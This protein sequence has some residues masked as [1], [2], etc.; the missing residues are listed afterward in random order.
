M[1]EEAKIQLKK[2][3]IEAWTFLRKENHTIPSETLD[4]IRDAAIEKLDDDVCP[5]K[6]YFGIDLEKNLPEQYRKLEVENTTQ[7][8]T[9]V[10][11]LDCMIDGENLTWEDGK[12]SSEPC[13]S[14]QTQMKNILEQNQQYVFVSIDYHPTKS[15]NME[16]ATL[17]VKEPKK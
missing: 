5:Y 16:Y 8:V 3:I 10:I 7:M 13:K 14:I 15:I 17:I 4:F 1:F 12:M 11:K 2:E 9:K 6:K